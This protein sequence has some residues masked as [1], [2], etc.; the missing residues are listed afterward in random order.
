MMIRFAW[1]SLGFLRVTTV[2]VAVVLFVG[3]IIAVA[4]AFPWIVLLL[5]VAVAVRGFR[6]RRALTARSTAGPATNEKSDGV[7]DSRMPAW[8]DDARCYYSEICGDS[9][10]PVSVYAAPDNGEVSNESSGMLCLRLEPRFYASALVRVLDAGGR[11]NGIIRSEGLVPGM[12]YAMRRNGEPVWRLSVRSIVRKRHA[13]VLA[14]GDSWTFETPFFWWQNLTGTT[15]GAPS[16]LG[17]LVLPTTRV[18]AM[19]SEPGRDTFDIL[20]AVAFMHR[21]WWHW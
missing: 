19:W 9:T 1:E 20:A 14:N 13:L 10:D 11:E 15:S 16:V 4:E 21:Q 17:G 8:L 5:V 6:R 3:V 7:E 2:M 18:W 12:S